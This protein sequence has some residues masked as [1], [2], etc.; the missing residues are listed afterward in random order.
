[1]LELAIVACG[2]AFG[3]VAIGGTAGVARVIWPCTA[4][5]V[6]VAAAVANRARVRGPVEIADTVWASLDVSA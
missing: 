2:A 6:G 5:A 3:A 1:L 4:A